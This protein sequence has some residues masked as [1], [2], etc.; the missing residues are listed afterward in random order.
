MMKAKTMLACGIML[1]ALP[2]ARAADT[3]CPP[4]PVGSTVNGNLIVPANQTCV[5]R[6]VTVTGNV[7]IQTNARLVLFAPLPPST[8]VGNVSVGTG[9]SLD[10]SPGGLTIDGNLDANQCL[11]VSLAAPATVGGNVQIQYCTSGISR[12]GVIIGGNVACN[13]SGECDLN[14]NKVNG[15]VEVNDNSTANVFN[16]TIGNNLQCQ[17]NAAITGGGNSVSGHKSGQCAN[18]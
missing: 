9:A 13:N 4:S 10:A 11:A 1:A 15:N 16:N 2:T 17:G 6:G 14:E 8:I 18:F 3:T 12:F 5:V 7:Q